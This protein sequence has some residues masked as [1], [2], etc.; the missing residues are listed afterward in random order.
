MEKRSKKMSGMEGLKFTVQ[1]IIEE[2]GA[3]SVEGVIKSVFETIMTI[4]R[5]S[6]LQDAPENNKANGYYSRMAQGVTKLFS[7]NVPRDRLGLF[8]PVFLEYQR[9]REDEMNDLAFKLYVKG[10][11]TRDI[12]SL[13]HDIYQTRYSAS[14]VS[15]MSKQ[16]EEQR[17]AWLSRPLDTQYYALYI[18]ALYINV[19]R[20]TVQK[21][22]FYLVMGL[23]TDLTREIVG[24][25]TIPHE[26]AEGWFEVLQDLKKRGLEQPLVLVSDELLHIEDAISRVFPLSYHQFCSTHKKRS[27]LKDVR[28]SDK[29]AMARD[30]KDLFHT[31]DRYYTAEKGEQE[32]RKFVDKWKRS[33]PRIGNKFTDMKRRLYFSYLHFPHEIQNMIYTTNWVERLNKGIRRTEKLRNS[34]PSPNSAMTLLCAHLMEKEEAV[35]KYPVTAFLS[36]KEKLDAMLLERQTQFY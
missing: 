19:R 22:A 30:L 25:Y 33:Y 26:S 10:L 1:K 12:D 17:D 34:F 9:K 29:E 18:D 36:A 23:K 20:T 28:S 5:D 6:Y 7:M 31:G 15:Q 4:E 3:D 13:F 11:S 16:F 8:R 27:I 32:V 21:E 24:I 14:K 2:H 35:Y